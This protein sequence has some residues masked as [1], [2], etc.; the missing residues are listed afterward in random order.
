MVIRT[1]TGI[2]LATQNSGGATFRVADRSMLKIGSQCRG[3]EADPFESLTMSHTTMKTS[4][5]D[6]IQLFSSV[7]S[8]EGQTIH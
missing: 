7:S 1:H 3:F 5:Q 4:T 6:L 2:R 8:R